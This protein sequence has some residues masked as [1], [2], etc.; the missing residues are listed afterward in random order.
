MKQK[1]I[2]AILKALAALPLRCLYILSDF[3]FCI[4]FYVIGYRKK[5]VEKNLTESFPEKSRAE[6]KQIEKNFYRYLSDQIVET[7]KLLHISDK[8]LK[9]RVKV[10][11]YEIVNN[12]LSNGRNAVVFMG[13]YANWEWVQEI[14]RYFIPECFTASIYHPLSDKTWDNIY[15]KI[16]DR[17]HNHIIPSNLAIRALLNRDNM[18]W[19]CGF[20]ADQRPGKKTPENCVRF[21]NHDTYF[22]YGTEEI[23]RKTKAD[24]F[25]LEMNRPKRGYYEINLHKVIPEETNESYPFTR[26]FWKLFEKTIQRNPAIWLWSHNRWK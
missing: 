22:A 20:I 26:E 23:G 12:S 11:N 19:V 17:W 25:Y 16:R 1:I 13:H 6:I 10:N 21:L 15:K 7:I 3:V 24:F 2:L 8:Q 9:K 5:V 18:P 4:V 14:S